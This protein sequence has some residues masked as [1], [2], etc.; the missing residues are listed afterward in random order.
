[1][2]QLAPTPELQER[3]LEGI[4]LGR[5]GDHSELTDLASYLI[6]DRAGYINGD[7]ITIDGGEWLY[8]GGE[9]NKLSEVTPEQWDLIAE[10]TNPRKRR[11]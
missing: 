3:T 8:G 11:G 2:G 10:I 1:M 6:S 4:P 7:V 9:F 5:V